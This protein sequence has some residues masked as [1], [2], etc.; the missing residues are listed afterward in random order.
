VANDT[1]CSDY[2]Y[3]IK[4]RTRVPNLDSGKDEVLRRDTVATGCFEKS[5][6]VFQLVGAEFRVFFNSD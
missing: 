4:R 1:G 3:T 2:I 5:G 6:R